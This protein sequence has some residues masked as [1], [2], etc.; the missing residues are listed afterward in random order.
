MTIVVLDSSGHPVCNADI[1]LN[2]KDPNSQITS[3]S[4]ANGVTANS[5]CGL[6]NAQYITSTSG[7]YTV[8][9]SATASSIKTDFNTSFLV[10]NN[11]AFDIVRTAQSKI[12]PVNNPNSFGVKIDV[13]SFVNQSSVVIKESVPSVF[14]VKTD[15]N[16]QTVGDTKILTWNKS[17]IGNK[18]S[19]Q[20]S[21]SVPLVFPQLYALGPV[22][23]DYGNQKFTEARQWFVANDPQTNFYDP[24]TDVTSNWTPTP[25]GSHWSTLDDGIRQPTTPTTTDFISITAPS[26]STADVQ[27]VSSIT[28]TNINSI[29]L[30]YYGSTG[31]KANLT[32]K[33]LDSAGTLQVTGTQ[34]AAN[35]AAA[36]HSAVWN[37][38][39]NPGAARAEFDCIRTGGGAGTCEVDAWYFEVNS[40]LVTTQSLT[41][42]LTIS[43]TFKT[44]R[45]IPIKSLTESLGL[46]DTI[47]TTTAR[48]IKSL[49]ESLGLSDTISA[50]KLFTKSFPE[51]L[52]L[53]DTIST[54]T[55]RPIKSFPE[56]L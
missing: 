34:L 8:N 25:T 6:Y 48:P 28:Q 20:Y 19:V 3:L 26:S 45:I 13:T 14:D 32:P 10:Q 31:S 5:E 17:L 21:Y 55:A 27:A 30:W 12:D 22:E 44:T 29:T 7:N 41:D 36:W 47:S 24:T 16:V 38:P 2:V 53:S 39:S 56:S 40:Q 51:S 18:A 43:D 42:S 54:T 37:T 49:T 35:T 4:S 46:S 23:I 33:I 11:F 15:A 9:V 52:G 50:R 1:L